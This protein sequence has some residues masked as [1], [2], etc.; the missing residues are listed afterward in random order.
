MVNRKIHDI[1]HSWIEYE[2]I[3]KNLQDH[4]LITDDSAETF[5]ATL[6]GR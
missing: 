5:W 1:A 4:I 6:K 2:D 3:G